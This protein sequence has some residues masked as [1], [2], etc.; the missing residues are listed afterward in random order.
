MEASAHLAGFDLCPMVNAVRVGL[1]DVHEV[2][3]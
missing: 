3:A 1:D 2:L